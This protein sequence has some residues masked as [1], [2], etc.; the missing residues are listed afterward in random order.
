M[1]NADTEGLRI[2]RER[3]LIIAISKDDSRVVTN[4]QV[5]DRFALNIAQVN[6]ALGTPRKQQVKRLTRTSSATVRI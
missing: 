5:E 1:D 2:A 3:A 4:E 6:D